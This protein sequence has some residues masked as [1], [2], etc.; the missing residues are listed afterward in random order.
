VALSATTTIP[1]TDFTARLKAEAARL[2]FDR[3]G[4]APAVAPPGY[5]HFRDWIRKGFQAGMGYLERL[6]EERG[7]PSSVLDGVRSIIAVAIVYGE[8]QAA[9][10]GDATGKV[11]R[12]A[13]GEDYHGVFWRKL[14]QLLEWIKGECPDVRGRA[15]ADTAPL[16]E[17]DFAQLAGLGWIGKNTMLID[18]RLGSFTLL[19]CLLVDVELNYDPPHLAGHCGTCTRCLDACP[20]DAF[21]A[22]YQ[23]DA[24][25]CISYWTI[26]HKGMMPDEAAESLDGW[27]FGCDVCQD[28]CPWNRKAPRG[29]VRELASMEEWRAPDLL[30]WLAAEP[31]ELKGRIKGTALSRAKRSGL[32]RNAALILGQRKIE[33]AALILI[34]R[35]RDDDP[36][37]RAACA[38]ALGRIGDRDSENALDQTRNDSDPVVRD[39]VH[40]ALTRIRSSRRLGREA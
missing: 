22:P 34:D 5:E 8:P 31:A 32:L 25:K 15:V 4:V 24:R 33:R 21:A 23:L 18:K 13:Q 12:Y 1:A 36:V 29:T 17:R 20:T 38:W 27:A 35:L 7:D 10:G 16:L 11:A 40:R 3:V 28:V 14:E 39:V 26:E 2:G 37:V 6:E 9:G 19:G 30:D